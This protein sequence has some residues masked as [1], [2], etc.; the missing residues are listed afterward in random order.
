MTKQLDYRPELMSLIGALLAAGFKLHHGNNGGDDFA[1]PLTPNDADLAPFVDELMAADEAFLFVTY[2][3]PRPYW[4]HLV[5]GNSPGELCSNYVV[6]DQL[7]A[8]I[9]AESEKWFGREQ[10]KIERGGGL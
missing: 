2:E 4:I 3:R 10:P 6:F 7:D 9:T 5:F 1:A 8:V